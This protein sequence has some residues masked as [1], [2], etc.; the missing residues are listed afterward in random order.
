MKQRAMRIPDIQDKDYNFVAAMGM[1]S[2]IKNK[3]ENHYLDIILQKSDVY[4]K[5][6]FTKNEYQKFLDSASHI[7]NIE[8]RGDII[9][10]FQKTYHNFIKEKEQK[11]YKSDPK[12]NKFIES[13]D[14]NKKIIWGDCYDA[15]KK[16]KSESIHCM[17][18]SPPYYNAR[19]YSQWQN[20]EEYFKDMEKI[21]RQCYRVLDN[22]RVFVFNVGDIFDNDNLYTNSVWGKRRLPLGA[23]F[24]QLFEKVGFTFVDDII[25]D[26]GEVQSE[27]HKNG[28]RPYPF[29]QYPMNCYE[30]LL[31]F[32]KHKLDMTRYPCP[33]CGTI[34]VNG[35]S[36]TE[37]GLK[38][39]ECK[40]TDCFERSE[41]NRGKRFSAKTYNTQS[42]EKNKD[43]E[44]EKDFVY[45]WRRDIK[46]IN[47][48]I[49]INCKGDNIV[50]HTAP[51]PAEI[52]EFAVKMFSY[53]GEKVL[54]PFSGLGTSLK[55]A[56]GLGRIGVGVEKD[57]SI[58]ESVY[59]FIGKNN[60]N[61]ISL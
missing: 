49:K 8:N 31:I 5:S 32:H 34:N 22:H 59:K 46:K 60:L 24:I 56:S 2:N 11:K 9:R 35:N 4:L 44:I 42:P 51:F 29:Y 20:L 13:K 43:S 10:E 45:S 23:Y 47:P 27:R 38:S 26:K 36:Y 6:L 53:F 19:E 1:L 15:L 18:T 41:S 12:I 3:R 14:G 39:W 55:V 17:V 50:G 33:I 7:F 21:I 28:D 48:V 16:I 30:H 37:K 40:N 25:W 52:P 61:E 58:K 57:L 54:D